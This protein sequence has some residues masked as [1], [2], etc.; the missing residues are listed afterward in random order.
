LTWKHALVG[1]AEIL[2]FPRGE[3][4]EL[5]LDVVRAEDAAQVRDGQLEARALR[6]EAT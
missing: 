5:A 6:N 2:V 3:L 4:G 1:G